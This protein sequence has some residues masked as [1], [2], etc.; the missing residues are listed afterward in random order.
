MVG[1][2]K[3]LLD[4]VGWGM[5]ADEECSFPASRPRPP[6][7]MRNVVGLHSLQLSG[8]YPHSTA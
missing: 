8:Q 1:D 4:W 5:G 7:F 3:C 6:M 2:V